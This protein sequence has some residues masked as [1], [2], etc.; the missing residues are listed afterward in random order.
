MF[1]RDWTQAFRNS[2]ASGVSDPKLIRSLM[3]SRFSGNL[4]IVMVVPSSADGSV[5]MWTREPS[6]RRASTIG[7]TRSSRRSSGRTIRCAVHRTCSS[8]SK[9]RSVSSSLPRTSAKMI[10]GPLTMISEQ[11]LSRTIGS[12]APKPSRSSS[13]PIRSS[14]N[15]IGVTRNSAFSCPAFSITARSRSRDQQDFLRVF[16]APRIGFVGR[17][18]QFRAQQL[19]QIGDFRRRRSLLARQITAVVERYVGIFG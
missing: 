9:V 19:P 16:P 7:C 15:S 8:S 10:F 14:A 18:Q 3:S 1:K 5:M 4:R 11:L 2:A 17:L 12:I 13:R 6:G